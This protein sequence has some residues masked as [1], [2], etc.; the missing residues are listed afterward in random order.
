MEGETLTLDLS[1]ASRSY[2]SRLMSHFELL[3]DFEE[4][5]EDEELGTV[6]PC[7][8]CAEDFDLLELCCHIDV[9]HPIEAK[10]GICPVCA[11]WVGTNMVEH[12][13][14]QHENIFKSQLKSKRCKH[15]SYPALSLSRKGLQDGHW[16]SFSAGL[17]PAMFTSKTACDP[18][19]SFLYG[20]A[21]AD[22]RE[23]VQPD[24]SSE[25]CI[26]EISSDDTVLERDVQS[27]LYDKDEKARQS[28]FV[29][30]LLASAIID[31]D[32]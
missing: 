15:E 28:E 18:L 22:E 13:A 32:F 29:L 30:G 31:P 1:T 9:D 10:S 12:I 17:S 16:Q 19:V 25:L 26:E 20:T 3:I 8:F 6:Y 4:F 27:S 24:F 21:A 14:A 7:P 5:N 23:N 2:Q 11:M